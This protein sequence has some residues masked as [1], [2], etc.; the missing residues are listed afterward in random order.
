ML[1]FFGIIQNWG[2]NGIDIFQL[3]IRR[4]SD[5]NE[6]NKIEYDFI[7]NCFKIRKM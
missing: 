7:G 1:Q 4:A 6:I 2:V 5:T 3:I